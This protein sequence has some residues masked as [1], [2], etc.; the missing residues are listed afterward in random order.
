MPDI[1][2]VSQKKT[3]FQG[4][5]FVAWVI[6]GLI[7]GFAIFFVTFFIFVDSA[8]NSEGFNTDLW[9]FSLTM[10]SSIVL[11]KKLNNIYIYN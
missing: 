4:M 11:V 9:G 8:F 7:D 5:S 1:Y 3:I 10:Y 6:V 2:Y